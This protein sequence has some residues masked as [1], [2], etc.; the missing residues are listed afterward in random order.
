[1]VDAQIEW[2]N[3]AEMDAAAGEFCEGNHGLVKVTH[4][5]RLALNPAQGLVAAADGGCYHPMDGRS[6]RVGRRLFRRV[7]P[8]LPGTRVRK[9]GV[10]FS[11]SNDR[12]GLAVRRRPRCVRFQ[13]FSWS[14]AK[15][16]GEL[17]FVVTLRP[18]SAQ[19]GHEQCT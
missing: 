7:Q 2:N 12:R 13:H 6:K 10:S 14:F 19:I 9:T 18:G 16:V 4:S 3:F 11:T 1:M 5:G 8:R 17:D 15:T